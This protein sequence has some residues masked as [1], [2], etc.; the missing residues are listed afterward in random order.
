MYNLNWPSNDEEIY[1]ALI[2]LVVD[3]ENVQ[4]RVLYPSGEFGCPSDLLQ[5]PM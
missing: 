4:V 1:M 2:S 5:S 3:M